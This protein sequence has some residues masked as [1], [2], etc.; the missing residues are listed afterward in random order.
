MVLPNSAVLHSNSSN[1]SS[2][3]I[4]SRPSSSI[5]SSR[6][7]CSRSSPLRTN[8]SSRL[9][10]RLMRLGSRHGAVEQVVVAVAQG[11]R[12][13]HPRVP[14]S[15]HPLL[16]LQVPPLARLRQRGAHGRHALEVA[17]VAA[18]ELVDAECE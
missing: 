6:L 13:S 8:S 2:H 15:R 11:G 10:L 12:H 16:A 1:I 5:R 4:N 7:L 9:R 3:S 17:E 14:R 18:V